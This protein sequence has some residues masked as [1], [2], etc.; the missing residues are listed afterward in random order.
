M[1]HMSKEPFRLRYWSLVVMSTTLVNSY[2][3]LFPAFAWAIV[4]NAVVL[5]GY[6]HYV[7]AVVSE[8]CDYLHIKCFQIPLVTD[9]RKD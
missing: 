9:E 6:L 1:S 4:V 8:I 7:T 5:A 3:H 2:L